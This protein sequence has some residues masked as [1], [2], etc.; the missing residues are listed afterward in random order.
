MCQTFVY[1]IIIYAKNINVEYI[2]YVCKVK[3]K[4]VSVIAAVEL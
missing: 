4:P 1:A 2:C 3:R